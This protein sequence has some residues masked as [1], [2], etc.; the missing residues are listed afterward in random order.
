MNYFATHEQ[1]SREVTFTME[2]EINKYTR[3][4]YL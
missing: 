2:M 4:L 1:T 3:A